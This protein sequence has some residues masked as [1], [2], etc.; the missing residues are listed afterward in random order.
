MR[1]FWAWPLIL[2]L[3][4][5]SSLAPKAASAACTVPNQ[6]TNGQ[7]ADASQVMAN[8][9]SVLG[10]VNTAPAGSTNALQ[11]N[12][13]SG[14]FA[15]VGPLTN[16]QIPIGSTGGPPQAA[17]IT[18]GS[19]ITVTNAPGSITVSSIGGGGGAISLVSSQTVSGATE[20][21]FT[22]LSSNYTYFITGDALSITSAGVLGGQFGTGTG[23]TWQ[24]SASQYAW[25]NYNFDGFLGNS[26]TDS[27]MRVYS[28]SNALSGFPLNLTIMGA[29]AVAQSH[30]IRGYFANGFDQF[31]GAD[32]VSEVITAFRLT[33]SAG[34][35]SGTFYLYS[36]AQ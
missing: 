7:T 33:V 32:N 19:G 4:A 9:N 27:V 25:N 11:Y 35:I 2:I 18:A 29:P 23:P 12:A 24:T 20:V 22:G 36:V 8:F 34:T 5:L 15:G 1:R 10:C 14:T 21:D 16:G 30:A 31:G 28:L 26:P 6:L 17:T 13:G 3:V